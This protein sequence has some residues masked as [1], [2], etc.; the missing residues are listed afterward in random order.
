MAEEKKDAWLNYLALTT[1]VLAVCAT[2]STFK[3]SSF[4][5]RSVINQN[6][7][8]NQW[9]YFQSKSIKGYMFDLQ[10]EMLELQLITQAPQLTSPAVDTVRQRIDEYRRN[11]A[12]YDSEKVAI[13]ADAKKYEDIRDYS[14]AHSRVFGIAVIYL[15][16]GILLS[17]IAALLKKRRVWYVGLVLGVIGLGYF[18]Y[19]WLPFPV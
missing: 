19:A 14:Q 8:A 16:L 9:S 11:I 7:A 13:T 2:L 18:A 17:S 10:K 5:T 4:S 6:L 1:V 15:Q 3:G 12:R